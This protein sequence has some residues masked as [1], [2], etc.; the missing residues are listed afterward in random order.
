MIPGDPQTEE[1]RLVDLTI[2]SPQPP[3]DVIFG[4]S[5][6]ARTFAEDED[7]THGLSK[8]YHETRKHLDPG[9]EIPEK[10]AAA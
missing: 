5:D 6:D 2:S 7:Q 10:A 3:G 4:G 1:E 9:Y 8:E